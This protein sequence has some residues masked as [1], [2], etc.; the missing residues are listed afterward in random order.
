MKRSDKIKIIRKQLTDSL[1][2]ISKL[3]EID[4]PHTGWI[5]AI[6]T[7]LGMS[8][9]TLAGRLEVNK[10]RISKIEQDEIAGNLTVKTMQKVADGLDCVFVYGFV[11]RSSLEETVQ[12]QAYLKASE[13]LSKLLHT[14]KLE[15]QN[16]SDYDR[17][18]LLNQMINQSLESGSLWK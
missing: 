7:A 17:Q 14:M 9:A 16:I 2:P 3:I 15:A 13:E 12:K 18:K 4:R 11:P 6:R 1:K 10:S 8:M 5:R